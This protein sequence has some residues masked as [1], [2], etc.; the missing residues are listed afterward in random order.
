MWLICTIDFRPSWEEVPGLIPTWGQ[1]SGVQSLQN[2]IWMP[3]KLVSHMEKFSLETPMG[4]GLK[5][6]PQR[7]RSR[8][9]KDSIR[10]YF[11]FSFPDDGFL[12][13]CPDPAI[14]PPL[15]AADTELQDQVHP[16]PSKTAVSIVEEELGA[17][18]NKVFDFFDFELIAAASLAENR[19][20]EETEERRNMRDNKKKAKKIQ[21]VKQR[22]RVKQKK[23]EI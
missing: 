12:K 9:I 5:T 13:I 7:Y 18:V 15:T 2:P 23:D 8:L 10:I 6:S 21:V 19:I 16:F 4:R 22:K 1:K 14:F 3:L 20:M 17:P 11:K